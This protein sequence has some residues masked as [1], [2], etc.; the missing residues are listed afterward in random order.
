MIEK[1]I[2]ILL[3]GLLML[4]NSTASY[5]LVNVDGAD[6]W[7]GPH[8]TAQIERR[9]AAP[10]KIRSQV[11]V[12]AWSEVVGARVDAAVPRKD[13]S[14]PIVEGMGLAIA[15]TSE[16]VVTLQLWTDSGVQVIR[17]RGAANVQ[18]SAFL[19]TWM[20]DPNASKSIFGKPRQLSVSSTA[21]IV[22]FAAKC[23]ETCIAIPSK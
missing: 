22:A 4:W 14:F 20:D 21:P 2:P 13:W 23:R 11:D 18:F 6:V 12:E 5:V 1:L 9:I 8:E 10:S 16:S 15:T 19:E 7:L 17:Y 3:P